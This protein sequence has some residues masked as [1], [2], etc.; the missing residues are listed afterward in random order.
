MEG[1][2]LAFAG[3]LDA[4][5]VRQWASATPWVYPAANVLHVLGVALLVGGIGIV[6]LRMAGLWR[7]LPVAP[8]SRALTPVAVAGLLI[9]V[10]SGLVLFA[11]DAAALAVSWVFRLKLVFVAAALLNALIFRAAWQRRIEAGAEIPLQARVSAFLSLL[12]WLTVATLGRLIA[13]V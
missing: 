9:L 2:L 10:A 4:A 13:Y 1:A 3:W 12:V 11:A 6:D 8:L 5:G 7:N